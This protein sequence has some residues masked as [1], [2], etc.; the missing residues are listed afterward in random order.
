M[1]THTAM[2]AAVIVRNVKD[3]GLISKISPCACIR[4]AFCAS[5]RKR[6]DCLGINSLMNRRIKKRFGCARSESQVSPVSI[7]KCRVDGDSGAQ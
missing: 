1:I 4:C 7:V 6:R 2:Q 5:E 3:S